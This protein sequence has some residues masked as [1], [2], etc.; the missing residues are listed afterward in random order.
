MLKTI[1]DKT[2]HDK[3]NVKTLRAIFSAEAPGVAG[4]GEGGTAD[5]G[6]N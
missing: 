2:K 6:P 3:P 5:F 4:E 1:N